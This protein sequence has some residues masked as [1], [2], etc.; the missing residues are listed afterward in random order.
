MNQFQ[1]DVQSELRQVSNGLFN[2]A[3]LVQNVE[4]SSS[5]TTINTGGNI[6][7]YI[8]VFKSDTIDVK[9]DSLN[10]LRLVAASGS[11]TVSVA[12]F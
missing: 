1:K 4:V 9:A 7:G 10:P 6:Q 11:V 2:G 3:R 12:V 5:G 8:I